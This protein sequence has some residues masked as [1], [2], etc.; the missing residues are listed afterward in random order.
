MEKE[1]VVGEKKFVVRE[2]LAIET[3]DINWDNRAEAIKKQVM[4]SAGIKE[5][6]YNK[7]TVKERLAIVQTINE[8]N[9]FGAFQE[10]TK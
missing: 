5:E 4:L 7:L 10:P 9:G 2:M 6:E 1:I 8:I 3:D